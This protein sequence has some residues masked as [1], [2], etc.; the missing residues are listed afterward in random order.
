MQRKVSC[1]APEL[2]DLC[3]HNEKA[4]SWMSPNPLKCDL[5]LNLIS[6]YLSFCSS[7]WS[8]FKIAPASKARERLWRSC[9]IVEHSIVP[10]STLGRE[11]NEGV[12]GEIVS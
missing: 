1:A 8:I 4:L 12:E 6:L 9:N 7:F 11:R 5:A 2:I 3:E 10:V